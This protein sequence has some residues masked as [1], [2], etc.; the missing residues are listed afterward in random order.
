MKITK[1]LSLVLALTMVLSLF[2]G[3]GKSESK[4]TTPPAAQSGE[5]KGE[6]TAQAPAEEEREF[7]KL[8][9]YISCPPTNDQERIMEKANEIIKEEINAELNLVL[10]DPGMY[11]EKINLMIGSGEEFDLC[12]MAN[13]GDM[14]FFENAAKGA[15][16]DMTELL[17]KYAPETY[18]RIPEALWDGVKV[19]GKIYASVNYQQWGVAAR[20]GINVRMDI[21]EECGFDWKQLKGKPA[22]EAMEMLTPF[23]EQAVAAHP[24]MI[25]WETSS[26][27]SF[28]LNDP[29]YWDMEPVGDMTQPGWIRYTE[30]DT[31]INQFE[32][33]EFA[34]YCDIMRDWNQKGLVRKDGATLQDTSPDRQSNR[35]IAE[36]G[37]GWPDYIDFPPT[38]VEELTVEGYKKAGYTIEG[39]SMTQPGEA[40]AAKV[41]TTRTVIP[42]AAAP[43][44][45]V[46]ISATSQH[47]E[48]AM[49]LIE[50]INTNDELFNLLQWGEEGVDYK[51]NDNGDFEMIPGKYSLSYNEWQIGQSYSPDFSRSSLSRNQAGEDAKKKME[52]VFKADLEADPSPVTGFTFDATPVKTELANCAAIISECVPV[53]SNGAADPAQL[54]PEFLSR[55]E[56]AGVD[57]IIAEKQAQL[58]A[59]K[60]ANGK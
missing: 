3:C 49:E 4:E 34:A 41:S 32:T 57:T 22:L 48:R 5:T 35:N 10:V 8:N 19:N 12:F 58:D 30:P 38:G 16:V 59:W 44:A 17:P 47:P 9:F 42:A 21:A 31:V 50:L 11:A 20:K 15:F 7:V 45:C 1:L 36:W 43:T 6:E 23:L 26:T 27:Y 60:A 24:E 53:L 25:G 51:Y 56:N 54:L 37:Y 40:P 13:W 14:N 55:L 2:A 29:L 46:A 39:M 18:A 28:F 52:M 33:P